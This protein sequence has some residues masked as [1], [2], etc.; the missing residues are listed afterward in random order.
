LLRSSAYATRRILAKVIGKPLHRENARILYSP[1]NDPDDGFSVDAGMT[2]GVLPLA[3]PIAKPACHVLVKTAH[4][5][6]MG[7]RCP[8]VKTLVP[9]GCGYP[10]AM[11]KRK[12]RG[13]IESIIGD[14][15]DALM[16]F[17]ADLSTNHKVAKKADVPPRT[18]GR[19]R[20]AEVSCSV[21]TLPK[22]AKVF[23]IEPWHLLIP[24]Y[25]PANPP[26]RHLTQAERQLYANL[27]ATAK[28]IE[29]REEVKVK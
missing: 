2:R 28:Q 1:F 23:G 27:R 15:L 11:A 17:R 18:I 10:S 12:P 25:D 20:N 26:V 16:R 8:S 3:L 7:H 13:V 6:S 19:I 5:P 21:D 9:Q 14:N 29:E 24:K 22:V 4:L